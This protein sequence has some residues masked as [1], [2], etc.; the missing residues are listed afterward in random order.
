[1][2]E[3]EQLLQSF[4]G[5]PKIGIRDWVRFR[6]S[7]MEAV[8]DE[9]KNGH[10]TRWRQALAQLKSPETRPVLDQ[11]VVWDGAA[12]VQ[13]AELWQ[14]FHPWRK[15]PYRLGTLEIDTEWRSDLKWDRLLPALDPLE[16]RCVLDVGCG[17][18]Y[19]CWRMRGAGAAQVVGLDP[20]LLYVMQFLAVW[21]RIPDPA[22]RVLPLGAEAIVP[23]LGF[24]TVFSMGV[25]SHCR[26]PRLHLDLLKQALR[27]GG[28]LILETLT[29]PDAYGPL[30][31]PGGRY[32]QMRNIH[33]LPT[34]STLAGWLREAGLNNIEHVDT[35][36]T[37]FEEQ[38][39]TPWMRFHSLRNYLD[40]EDPA[41]TV[42]GHPAPQR[43]LFSARYGTSRLET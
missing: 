39:A 11:S 30:F 29:V 12:D 42:E 6:T 32:A 20:F 18:G 7:E 40:P 41:K 9:K 3:T 25:L 33:A 1:M 34:V 15:G 5:F 38:R 13:D 22:V 19:H 4:E 37:G 35:A 21:K 10:L 16:G 26:E 23:G 27:P 28:Q 36:V 14:E 8:F 2:T 43:S 17:N 31:S 24:D